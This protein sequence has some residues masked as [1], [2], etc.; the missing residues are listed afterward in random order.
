MKWI[1]TV[2]GYEESPG[3][4]ATFVVAEL[5]A[6]SPIGQLEFFQAGNDLSQGQALVKIIAPGFWI[7]IEPW[8]DAGKL[9]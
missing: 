6:I 5:F 7:S 4:K 1:V 9:N 2:P 3:P 8:V